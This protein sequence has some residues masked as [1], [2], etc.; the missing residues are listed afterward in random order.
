[1]SEEGHS[2][3]IQTKIQ[4]LSFNYYVI[5]LNISLSTELFALSLLV[6]AIPAHTLV[7]DYTKTGGGFRGCILLP[8]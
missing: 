2:S 1:M 8:S 6:R 5:Y 3:P 4:F 7:M